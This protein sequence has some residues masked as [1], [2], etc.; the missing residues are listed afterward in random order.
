M[1]IKDMSI[2]GGIPGAI[3]ALAAIITKNSVPD[4][5]TAGVISSLSACSSVEAVRYAFLY[6]T[7]PPIADVALFTGGA[8]LSGQILLTMA[9]LLITTDL[10]RPALALNQAVVVSSL[11]LG[12]MI[13]RDL[14]YRVN[15]INGNS[16]I[17]F[18][19]SIKQTFFGSNS[20]PPK[21]ENEN[22]PNAQRSLAI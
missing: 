18:F 17:S 1:I 21:N 11:L 7:C 15:L 16:G 13:Y 8:I 20:T 14:K 12:I 4:S 9:Q 5:I 6:R 2:I 3:T 10:S 19:G 22:A